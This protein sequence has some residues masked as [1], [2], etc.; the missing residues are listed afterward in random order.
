[1]DEGVT[2][3]QTSV[4]GGADPA[5]ANAAPEWL[6]SN[7][8]LGELQQVAAAER[9]RWERPS[10]DSRSK[11]D[12]AARRRAETL[13]QQREADE[14]RRRGRNR[15]LGVT[16]AVV[17]LSAGGWFAWDGFLRDE[18]ARRRSAFGDG[19]P[20]SGPP[21]VD[22]PST[23]ASLEPVPPVP[24][25]P[26]QKVAPGASAPSQPSAS[27][28]SPEGRG[29]VN[30]NVAGFLPTTAGTRGTILLVGFRRPANVTG[31]RRARIVE[32]RDADGRPV[33][34]IEGSD[35]EILP[36]EDPTGTGRIQL[37]L[38]DAFPPGDPRVKSLVQLEI[39]LGAARLRARYNRDVLSH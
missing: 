16:L 22:A 37:Q 30:S 5:A 15:L 18:I 34:G 24:P 23:T 36:P 28:L 14:A 9:N 29:L 35:A 1:M 38:A 12:A 26:A 27:P 2:S 32:A 4:F 7:D 3:A 20:V 8:Q 19:A 25:R 33:A 31:L 13:R 17:G 21:P 6:A 10:A 11:T 39:E